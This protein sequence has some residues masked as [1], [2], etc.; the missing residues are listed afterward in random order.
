MLAVRLSL[1]GAG[2]RNVPS[3]ASKHPFTCTAG[4]AVMQ[5]I[6]DKEGSYKQLKSLKCAFSMRTSKEAA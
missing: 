2:M 1:S 5:V 4:K 6:K 3:N